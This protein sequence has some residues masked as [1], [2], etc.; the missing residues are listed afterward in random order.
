LTQATQ[1]KH[2]NIKTHCTKE[3]K[4]GYNVATNI[5]CCCCCCYC[6]VF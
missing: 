1:Y 3:D 2:S 5:C 6:Y 4:K